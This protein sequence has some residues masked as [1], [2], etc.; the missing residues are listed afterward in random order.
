MW[1]KAIGIWLLTEMF[2]HLDKVILLA[3]RA[4]PGQEYFLQDAYEFKKGFLE[5]IRKSVIQAL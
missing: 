2:A 4:C 1:R 3:R 5:C